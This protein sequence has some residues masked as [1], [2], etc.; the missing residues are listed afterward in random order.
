MATKVLHPKIL[1]LR[2]KIGYLPI[3]E[4]RPNRSKYEEVPMERRSP[5]VSEVESERLIKQYFCIWGVPD[6]YRTEPMKG[7]FKKSLNERG[8]GTNAMNKIIVLNQHDQKDPLCLPSVLKEDEIGLYGEYEP[9]PIA[10]GDRLI[11]QIRRKTINQGSYGFNYVWDKMEYDDKTDTIKMY[12]CELF[13]VSPVSIGSQSGT[14]VVRNKKT[15]KFED[16]YLEDETEDLIK[17]IPRKYQLEI[18]TLIT[19][20]ISLAKLQPL[21]QRQKA[22]K[23][24]KP[25]QRGIDYSFLTENL[26]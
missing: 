12:E 6:D 26:T 1:E 25:K 18:R 23:S 20:H 17:Q 7:C 10:S 8:P 3:H 21:E 16:K 22:L 14:F 24:S 13:E 19:R 11:I 9:D 5:I 4:F 15:G 2:N